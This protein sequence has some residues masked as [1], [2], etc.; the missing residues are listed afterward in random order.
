MKRHRLT[1]AVQS[2]RRDQ[3]SITREV[4]Y[5]VDR[6]ISREGR[7]VSLG[8]LVFFST[9]T[10]DAWVLD[11]ED[12][13]ASPLARNGD[14]LPLRLVE[15]RERFAVEWQATY[16]IVGKMMV[17]T[18]PQGHRRSVMGYPVK[19]ILRSSQKLAP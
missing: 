11:P 8:S 3:I 4:D 5:I 12:G 13:L 6:A 2:L 10:G 19:E 17:F 7:V 9:D 1:L 14:R 15:T 16:S 18:D